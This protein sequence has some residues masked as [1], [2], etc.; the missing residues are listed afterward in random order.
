MLTKKNK[1]V[2]EYLVSEDHEGICFGVFGFFCACPH[3][4]VFR[5]CN[6]PRVRYTGG[7][8]GMR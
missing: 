4:E 8:V 2:A 7:A 1:V 5:L 3:M 6:V